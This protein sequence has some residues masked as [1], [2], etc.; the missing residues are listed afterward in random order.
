[1]NYKELF[2]KA[3]RILGTPTNAWKEI[4][5]EED[6]VA[7]QSG[8]VYPMTA[9]CGLAMLI[10]LYFGNGVDTFNLQLALMKCSGLFVSLFGGYFLS[11][12]LVG[13]YGHRFSGLAKDAEYKS[14][15]L[16]GYSMCLIFVLSIFSGLFPSFFIL[17][18][19]LQFYLVYIVWEGAKVLMEIPE[20]RLLSYTLF[21]SV[22]ILAVPVAL[23]KIFTWLSSTIC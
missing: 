16:V 20:N 12:Y 9:L 7:V 4:S 17:R 11:S 6:N 19:I 18:W 3:M 23:A 22:I 21:V 15:Q 5:A 2:A 14:Q 13:H 1:M 10:G 8:F